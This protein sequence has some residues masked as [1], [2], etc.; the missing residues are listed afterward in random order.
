MRPENAILLFFLIT[1]FILMVGPTVILEM[2]LP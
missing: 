2:Y 1:F